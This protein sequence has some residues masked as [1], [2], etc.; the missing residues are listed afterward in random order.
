MSKDYVTLLLELARPFTPVEL[1]DLDDWKFL[2]RELGLEFPPDSKALVSAFGAGDFGSGL[3]LMNPRASA[4]RNHIS[5]GTL[6]AH[7]EMMAGLVEEFGLPLYPDSEGLV[8]IGNLD[9]QDFFL[10][11]HGKGKR[12]EQLVWWNIDMEGVSDLKTP[13]SEFLY[14]LH[15]GRVMHEWAEELREYIWRNGNVPFF[16]PWRPSHQR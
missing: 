1:P 5:R 14:E 4:S 7:R 3:V 16:T 8:L 10:R 12:L 6:I 9:R 13:I 2:E 11:P 15:F